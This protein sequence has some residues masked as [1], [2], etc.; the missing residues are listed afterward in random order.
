MRLL[1]HKS[2]KLL[3]IGISSKGPIAYS[4]DIISPG[5]PSIDIGLKVG[6]CDFRLDTHLIWTTL[7]NLKFGQI[8][9]WAS[10]GTLIF[11][12]NNGSTKED[13]CN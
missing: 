5:V 11:V 10:A 8:I 1:L 9:I 6:V 3:K 13:F 7:T 12:E 2:D 4:G